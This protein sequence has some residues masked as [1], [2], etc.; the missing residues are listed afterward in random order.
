MRIL[1]ISINFPPL[2]GM[3]SR[4]MAC[5]AGG[6]AS[7]GHRVEVLTIDPLEG[8]P[9]HWIDHNEMR[10]LHP[11]VVIHRVRPGIVNRMAARMRLGEPVYSGNSSPREETNPL[12]RLGRRLYSARHLWQPFAIPDANVDWLPR[13][14]RKAKALLSSDSFDL[15]VTHGAPHTCHLVGYYAVQAAPIRLAADYGDAWGFN[16]LLD[17][18]PRWRVAVERYLERKF[19]ARVDAITTSSAGLARGFETFYAVPPQKITVVPSSFLD[20]AEYSSVQVSSGE[21]FHLV[22]TGTFYPGIQDPYEFFK[23][24]K[25]LERDDLR[26]TIAGRLDPK[27]EN[28]VKLK[29]LGER[30]R[31]IGRVN[32]EEVIRLQKSATALLLLG[33]VGGLQLSS[34]IYE[35][36]AARRPIF[37]VA[38]DKAD[39][40]AEL[41]RRHNR[42][43]VVDNR[44]DRIAAG[45]SALISLVK[46]G[47]GCSFNLDQLS[48]YCSSG[49][50]SKMMSGILGE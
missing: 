50:V 24:L 1:I 6:L 44:E 43:L 11:D 26:V 41:V 42:G 19:L 3:A 20:F 40:G 28:F 46:P 8:H 35:Y 16:M 22:Y 10:V 30:V 37:C 36:F 34:K 12:T 29:G 5:L 39:L 9:V 25:G 48:E 49:A 7:A 18:V 15:V 47:T 38:A 27:I 31:L 23:A 17:Q 21:G 33:M 45:L 14:L 13:A 2:L 4:R 32:R